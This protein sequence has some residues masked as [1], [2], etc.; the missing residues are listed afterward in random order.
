AAAHRQVTTGDED[1][2]AVQHAACHGA[3]AIDGGDKGMAGAY[4]I[5]QHSD[6]EELSD[7]ADQKLM[8]GIEIIDDLSGI[9]VHHSESPGRVVIDRF[10]QNEV[11][12]L[13][14]VLAVL[15]AAARKQA[16]GNQERAQSRGEAMEQTQPI[17]L[18]PW[19]CFLV[20]VAVFQCIE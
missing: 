3:L 15:G 9:N 12:V 18:L 1:E 6:G 10:V 11:D 2:V 5:E 19:R 14:Y 4:V 7:R 20:T 17:T 8:L 16:R 13:G